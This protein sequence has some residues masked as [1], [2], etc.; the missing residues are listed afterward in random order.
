MLGLPKGEVFLVPWTTAWETEFILEKKKIQD[1]I[2]HYLVNVHHIGSTAVKNLSAK[3]IID[4][5]IEI[6]N[7]Q[8]GEK[9]I[10]SLAE[11]GYSYKGTNVLPDRYYF[12]KGEPRTHQIHMYQ[13]G[14][15][16]LLEQLSFR[17]YLRE[18]ET[19]RN[20]YEKLKKNLSSISGG[21]KHRYAAEKT[22]FVNSILE[23]MNKWGENMFEVAGCKIS[24]EQMKRW[25][26]TFLPMKEP[27]YVN[28]EQLL[29]EL[30]I[31]N[32]PIYSRDQFATIA[33]DFIGEYG[34]S[35]RHWGIPVTASIAYLK[36]GDVQDGI[37]RSKLFSHQ[38]ALNRGQIYTYKWVEELD[39]DSLINLKKSYSVGEERIILTQEAWRQIP[40]DIKQSWLIKW[41]KERIEST[42]LDV[43]TIHIPQHSERVVQRYVSTFPLKSGANCFSAAIG[44]YL[45]SSHITENWLNIEQFF[46]ILKQEGLTKSQEITLLSE[47]QFYHPHDVLVWENASGAAIHAAYAI[48]EQFLFNK[49]GQFWFQP[50]QFVTIEH[51]FDYA[52]CVTN[53]GCISIY[54]FK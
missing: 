50:W 32:I 27:F 24:P 8:D 16:Y 26:D 2:G 11:L 51:I 22:D 33:S 5:V 21:N 9:C 46:E 6:N 19:A 43:E 36:A 37:L 45:G 30:K 47:S 49:M 18:N 14:N 44:A 23:R 12:N 10:E 48:S 4:I 15:R 54:R 53:G 17:D 13:S 41:L 38:V 52:S 29:K 31:L 42:P 39:I 35:Y 3:P 40:E 25:T 34:A 28:D 20:Q 1:V 7:F